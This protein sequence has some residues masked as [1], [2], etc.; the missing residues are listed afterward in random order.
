[1]NSILNLVI[2]SALFLFA[3]QCGKED[4][5]KTSE[6][7]IKDADGKPVPACVQTK[8]AEIAEED[9]WNP[10]AKVYS[11]R[12]KEEA[13]YFI[14]QRC[15]DF[16]SQLLNEN[17]ETICMPDGGFSG[18]GDGACPEFFTE[19]TAEFLIWEDKR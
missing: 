6:G 4:V 5:S 16:P 18:S 7:T 1:M 14:P 11:Y 3:Q 19:R 15:C 10:P 9:V 13:V 8:I 17:C 12:Y 2:I